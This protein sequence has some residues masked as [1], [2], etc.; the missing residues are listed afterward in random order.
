M[1]DI[2]RI[3]QPY[4]ALGVFDQQKCRLTGSR[5]GLGRRCVRRLADNRCHEFY[6][7]CLS[8][9]LSER[10]GGDICLNWVVIGQGGSR[11]WRNFGD[12]VQS[13][14]RE[15]RHTCCR[16]QNN[17]IP[18]NVDE[19]V[20]IVLL[21]TIGKVLLAQGLMIV[22]LEK[23]TSLCSAGLR[24]LLHSCGNDMPCSPV[25]DFGVLDK[26]SLVRV[27]CREED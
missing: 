17:A 10:F 2:W 1:F 18:S 5:L 13:A 16:C 14:H 22:L 8:V 21:N 15:A 4:P 9:R 11:V 26:G 25:A 20:I 24:V 12:G 19:L 27:R 6:L 7:I 3:H 23:D